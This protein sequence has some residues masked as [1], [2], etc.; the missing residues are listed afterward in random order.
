MAVRIQDLISMHVAAAIL[1][2]VGILNFSPGGSVDDADPFRL[3]SGWRMLGFAWPF[4]AVSVIDSI[5]NRSQ[6][7]HCREVANRS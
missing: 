5:Q 4:L 1:I 6:R 7:R 2:V 3:L